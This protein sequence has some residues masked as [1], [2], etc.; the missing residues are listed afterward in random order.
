[1]L[2]V[3]GPLGV[4]V[5]Y[6]YDSLGDMT[7]VTDALGNSQT[8]IY[9]LFG[10]MTSTRNASGQ[11]AFIKYDAAGLRASTVDALGVSTTYSYDADNRLV[12]QTAGGLTQTYSYDGA[13]HLTSAVNSTAT[14][15]F[16]YDAADRATSQTESGPGL[17]TTTIS[18]TYDAAGRLTSITGPQGTIRRTYDADGRLTSITDGTGTSTFAYDSASQPASLVRPNG[19]TDSYTYDA[20]GHLT[21]LTTTAGGATVDSLAYTYTASGSIASRTQNGDTATFAYDPVGRLIGVQH[22]DPT[23]PAESFTYDTR[24][25]R[26]S[27]SGAPGSYSYS[28]DDQ[29]VS[30]P[31]ATF[32]YDLAGQRTSVTGAAGATSFV[33]DAN[34]HLKSVAGPGGRSV[35]FGYDALGRRVS[36]SDGTTTQAFVYSG[37]Q[38]LAQYTNGALQSAFTPISGRGAPLDV[39]QGGNKYFYL[40]DQQGTVNGLVDGS[41]AVA[42]RYS[43]SAFGA[44]GASSGS[45]ANPFTFTS[46]QYDS[47]AGAYYANA[48]YYDPQNGAFLSRD[49]MSSL[50]PYTYVGGDPVNFSDPTGAAVGFEYS[51]ILQFDLDLGDRVLGCITGAITVAI[52]S[53][54]LKLVKPQAFS[55]KTTIVDAGLSCALGA[56]FPGAG[57]GKSPLSNYPDLFPDAAASLLRGQAGYIAFSALVGFLFGF[58]L[59]VLNQAIC[60]QQIDWGHAVVAGVWGGIGGVAG[61]VAGNLSVNASG[62][63]AAAF[64]IGAAIFG[65]GVG[66]VQGLGDPPSPPC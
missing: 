7:S 57:R 34:H 4:S 25:N 12:S 52:T 20:A 50:N 55:A 41:G 66:S 63:V 48:R 64:A 21:G 30:S 53:A 3:S 59:D 26:T 23:L 18:D 61:G 14:V 27:W 8:A 17:P 54:I 19:A 37:S 60:G 43:Y 24:N 28:V 5:T 29:L 47:T 22:T 33:W 38:V 46:L 36:T 13:G 9:D 62:R 11:T 31:S 35:T 58:A 1:M 45:V 32:A 49:P 40:Q 6:A 42:Q 10:R 51:R 56:L 15:R 44:A 65:S 16:S 39:V 2:S